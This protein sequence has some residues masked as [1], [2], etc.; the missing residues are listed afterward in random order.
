MGR[1]TAR[2]TSRYNS[3]EKITLLVDLI[4]RKL[5]IIPGELG[6]RATLRAGDH[7]MKTFVLLPYTSGLSTQ[8]HVHQ[9][10]TL[11]LILS[12][13]CLSI[14]FWGIARVGILGDPVY[15]PR[16]PPNQPL[17]PLG[18][19]IRYDPKRTY[20]GQASSTTGSCR[21]CLPCNMRILSINVL[22]ERLE[23]VGGVQRLIAANS[24]IVSGWL[25][26]IASFSVVANVEPVL[27]TTASKKNRKRKSVPSGRR[28]AAAGA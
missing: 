24:P 11:Y 27:G 7:S 5:H 15:Q 22:V 6:T 23:N 18:S 8:G 12:R 17:A 25:S 28:S 2:C 19:V 14:D 10:R 16:L 13:S 4:H 1:P 3:V 9:R 21:F 26:G 20:Q